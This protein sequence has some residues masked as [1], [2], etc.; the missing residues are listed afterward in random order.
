MTIRDRLNYMAE[1]MPNKTIYVFPHNANLKLTF[2]D[3]RDRAL[4]MAQNFLHMGFKKGDRIALALPN[5]HEL[6]IAYFAAAYIGLIIVTLNPEYGLDELAYMI[7]KTTPVGFIV[8]D[9]MDYYKIIDELFP[10][11]NEFDKG[12]LISAKFP[13]L[14]H[15]ILVNVNKNLEYR[16]AWPY[17]EVANKR[18][19]P[20]SIYDMPYID[21]DDPF[22][23]IFTVNFL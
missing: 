4:L 23:I 16:G 10:E 22:G 9:Y 13:Y 5:T 11:I 15:I 6:L 18:I 12:Q 1:Q 2:T 19:N 7:E 14:K 17:E 8:Y 21:M 3:C 20:N